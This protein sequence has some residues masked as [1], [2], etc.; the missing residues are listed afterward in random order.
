MAEWIEYRINAWDNPKFRDLAEILGIT[1][2]EAIGSMFPFW[3]WV[4]G[5]KFRGILQGR[6]VEIKIAVDGAK[7]EEKDAKRVVAAMIEARFL[8]DVKDLNR[9]KECAK[10][11]S[12]EK[13]GDIQG[14][15]VHDWDEYTHFKRKWL[16]KTKNEREVSTKRQ[17]RWRAEERLKKGN[18]Y[19][20]TGDVKRDVTADVTRDK[21]VTKN[22][23]G[24]HTGPLKTKKGKK[25]VK[26][27]FGGNLPDGGKKTSVQTRLI[28]HWRKRFF[29]A[30]GRQCTIGG[31]RFAGTFTRLLKTDD[32]LQVLIHINNFFDS[33]DPYV[34]TKTKFSFDLFEKQYDRLAEGPMKPRTSEKGAD[35][36][37]DKIRSNEEPAGWKSDF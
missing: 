35:G 20:V 23:T 6:S 21:S 12:Q 36:G 33:T 34:T 29:E 27:L 5:N 19:R 37:L 16:T 10:F 14:Y 17:R 15:V 13:L 11:Y 30:T 28:D 24:Y 3:A 1:K 4:W 22:G 31:Q 25:N 8:H 7:F 9:C 2:K 18:A 32:E 26:D